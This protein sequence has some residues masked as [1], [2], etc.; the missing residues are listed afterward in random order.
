MM[1][2]RETMQLASTQ[3]DEIEPLLRVIMGT[4][5]KLQTGAR[6]ETSRYVCLRDQHALFCCLCFQKRN[7][8]GTR[9]HRQQLH[10]KKIHQRAIFM[11][12]SPVLEYIADDPIL[13]AVKTWFKTR[14]PR[15]TA[16]SLPKNAVVKA[17][18]VH[19]HLTRTAP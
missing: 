8:S 11:Q 1:H 7:V 5:T 3:L 9:M 4:Q 2:A 16:A 12:I 18:I 6:G 14:I 15:D 19:L 17:T 10:F 13:A